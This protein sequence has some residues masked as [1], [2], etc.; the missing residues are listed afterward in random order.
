[1]WAPFDFFVGSWEGAGKGQSGIS[2]VE[3]SYE[4]VLNGKFLHV[5]NKSTYAPQAQNP[6][7]EVHED[8]GFIS[9]D[10]TRKSFV[11][12]QFHVESFVNQFVQE[13]ISPD[14]ATIVFI[15]EQ[16]ENIPAGWRAKETYKILG[17]DEFS[18]VFE[19]AAPGQEFEVYTENHFRRAA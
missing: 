12:R 15:S 18:E 17:A 6:A 9:Y 14:G 16:I 10:R 8:W 13:S 2:T 1:M 11:L 19:L 3:R 5:R 7:G 4:L